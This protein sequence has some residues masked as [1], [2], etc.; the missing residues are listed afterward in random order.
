MTELFNFG[1]LYVSDFLPLDEQPRND[2]FEMKLMLDDNGVV[3]L[4]EQPPSDQM[5]GKYWYR[6]GTND[7]MKKHLKDLVESILSFYQVESEEGNG[8]WIDIASNDG[9]LLS[10]V[11]KSV[12]RI[13]VDP[14]EDTFRREA[15]K[16]A[17]LII[18]D[19]FS[20]NALLKSGLYAKAKVITCISMFYDLRDPDTFLQ[21]VKSVL[22]DDGIFVVQMSYTPLMIEQMA[23]DNVVHEHVAYYSLFNF[24]SL[25]EGNGFKVMDVSLNDCNGGSFRVC[26]MKQEGDETKFGKQPYRDVCKMRTV[27]LL[28]YEKKLNL[29][30]AITWTEFFRKIQE[31]KETTVSFVKEQKEKGKTIWGYGAST[32]GNTLLQYFG[33]DSSLI[34]GIAE[35]SKYKW[36]L[37]TAGTNIPIYSEEVMRSVKPD[38]LLVLPW[39]FIS[40]FMERE[41]KLLNNG[42]KFI[43]TCPKFEVIGK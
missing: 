13:G 16:H 31:L 9:T 10:F 4:E 38:Y 37:K 36:G 7:S 26:M 25:V 18:Q 41:K 39:H 11:P 2:P 24:K 33:L 12:I 32:K 8:V 17:D 29:D 15:E 14:C 28:E 20:S 30:S 6:S 21:D 5:W 3:R 23:F 42:T 34:D 22:H 1:K 27:S 43:V 40:E 35:R 19:Y